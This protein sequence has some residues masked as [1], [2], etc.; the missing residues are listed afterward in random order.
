MVTLLVELAI[1]CAA[2]LFISYP[3]YRREQAGAA[4]LA[5]SESDFSDLLYRKEAVYTALKDL[6]FDHSTGKIDD[7]DYHSI[8]ASLEGEAISLLERIENFEK[9]VQPAGA[10]PA[11]TARFCPSCGAETQKTHRFCASCG[12]K[13]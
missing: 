5:L 4:G 7:A 1:L 13:L 2:L 9:G 8:K 10:K 3:L 11:S 6:D 12:A